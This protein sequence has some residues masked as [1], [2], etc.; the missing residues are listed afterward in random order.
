M[1][2]NISSWDQYFRFIVGVVAI[3]AA[4]FW[5]S[6][7]WS[8]F[9]YALAAI[10][11]AT[12]IF[13]FC[14][15]YSLIHVAPKPQAKTSNL[16]KVLTAV[17]LV[18]VAAGGSYASIFF[19]RKLFL[20]DFNA[21]NNFYKQTL[22][23]TGQANREEAVKNLELWKPAFAAFREKYT[24]YRPYDLKNDTKLGSDFAEVNAILDSVEPMVRNGDLHE[25]HLALE[26]VRPIFQDTF[27]RNGFSLLAV[28]LVDFHD[29][30]E[31]I[32]T[33]ASAK[34]AEQVIAL[35]VPVNE[36][37]KVVEAEANDSDIQTIRKAL[38]ALHNAAQSGETAGLPELGSA[39]KSSFVKVYLQ[40][41]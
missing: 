13:R 9:A 21:M 20:E 3:E 26:K 6:S 38:D 37:L 2:K 1:V 41:G 10:L 11:V 35:Y 39:L 12:A 40:R 16:S 33:A 23:L 22:F 19:T 15:L 25:A 30:M 18:A 14:P 27:K 34:D 5:L 29:A 8:L 31:T 7:P 24:G 32:L 4:Y 36:K 17:L 28:A